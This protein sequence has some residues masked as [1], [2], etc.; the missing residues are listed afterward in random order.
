MTLSIKLTLFLSVCVILGYVSYEYKEWVFGLWILFP[1]VILLTLVIIFNK[2]IIV[3]GHKRNNKGLNPKEVNFLKNHFSLMHHITPEEEADFF[4][5]VSLFK[6]DKEFIA[7]GLEGVPYQAILLTGAYA[8]FFEGHRQEGVQIP[9]RDYPVFIFY[10]HAFPS[11]QYPQSLHIS[12]IYSEDGAMMFSIPHLIRGSKEPDRYL[13]IGLYEMAK[14]RADIMGL[15]AST[16]ELTKL[17]ATG[18]FS[19]LQLEKYIGLSQSNISHQALALVI[20]FSHR[21]RFSL[22]FPDYKQK[23]DQIFSHIGHLTT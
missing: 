2:E 14:T 5:K 18:G 11:P 8:A 19:V 1:S 22:A 16:L 3:W 12:E 21:T 13:D 4:Q 10:N 7:Q 23:L 9:L 17:C 6:V 15:D 20:Y